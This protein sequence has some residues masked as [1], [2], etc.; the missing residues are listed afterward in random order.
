MLCN[1]DV[2]KYRPVIQKILIQ[3][4]QKRKLNRMVNKAAF[5]SHIIIALCNGSRMTEVCK[6]FNVTPESVRGWRN[7]VLS[8]GPN[9]LMSHSFPRMQ[10][11]INTIAEKIA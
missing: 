2:Y 6:M 11:L 9:G 8:K 10:I 3:I 4:K 1:M 7:I 5:I